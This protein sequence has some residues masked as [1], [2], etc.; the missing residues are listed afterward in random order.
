MVIYVFYVHGQ[1]SIFTVSK[2][3]RGFQKL[4]FAYGYLGLLQADIGLD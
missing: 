4:S 3:F 2:Y 1:S